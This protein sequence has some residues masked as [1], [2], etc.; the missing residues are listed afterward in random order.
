MFGKI[1]SKLNL[2]IA[3]CI[4][5]LIVFL[6]YAYSPYS[7]TIHDIDV[8][9]FPKVRLSISVNADEKL[10]AKN[11]S[12]IE[13]DK[14][15]NG[16]IV[17]LPPNTFNKTI[18]LFIL[19]DK[20]GNTK[21]YDKIIKGNLNALIKYMQDKGVDLNVKLVT[22]GS[23]G[24]SYDLDL[25][26]YSDDL[27]LF[28][29]DI[30][31]V[32]FD[33]IRVERVFGLE[34]IYSLAAQSYRSNAEKVAL[35]INGSQYYDQSRGDNTT[36]DISDTI[37]M[38]AEKNFVIFVTG[39]PIKQ[40]VTNKTSNTEDGSLSHS[41][42]GGYLGYDQDMDG[43]VDY[44]AGLLNAGPILVPDIIINGQGVF[45]WIF[46]LPKK[47]ADYVRGVKKI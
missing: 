4:A 38:L 24:T 22:F 30:E 35:V 34:K 28:N 13:N 32:T 44:G 18:D 27:N 46:S 39:F 14:K 47:A 15:N 8:S 29:N 7:A 17:V 21:K 19:I 45:N 26:N 9:E 20:S 3:F 12:I 5:F 42:A 25:K 16:P 23:S 40:M 33:N 37:N 41:L 43:R 11:F 2:V 1:F 6:V 10:V 31:N 36:F